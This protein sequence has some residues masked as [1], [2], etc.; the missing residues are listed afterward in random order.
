MYM[1]KP[2]VD[3]ETIEN[4][5]HLYGLDKPIYIQYF[6]WLSNLLRG[7]LGRS[8]I[9][10]RPVIDLIKDRFWNTLKL[11]VASLSLSLVIAIPVG[12][13][14]AVKQYSKT[15]KIS[16]TSALF[17][18]SMPNFW[19]GLILIYTF[20]LWLPWL[21][22]SGIRSIGT[23]YPTLHQE[24]ID[25]LKHLILPVFVS[26]ASG[27]AFNSR[28]VRSSM[29]EILRQDY[30]LTA[31]SKGLKERVVIYKHALR[32][33][34]LPVVTVVGIS[35]GFIISGSAVVESVFSWPGMGKFVVQMAYARDYTVIM[36]INVVLSVMLTFAILFTDI[37]YAFLDPRIRY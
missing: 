8:I 17:F 13:I 2:E 16:M 31:R 1:D 22:S 21:P 34:L 29:L 36:G 18:W 3:P 37:T 23:T 25:Q 32:N 30:I 10:G 7:D 28:L 20:S 19:L 4:L 14:S 9:Q 27:A 35:L 5:K 11:A 26:G 15:D 6:V 12:V 24:I 33:G